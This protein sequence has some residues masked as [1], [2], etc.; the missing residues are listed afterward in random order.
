MVDIATFQNTSQSDYG[1]MDYDTPMQTSSLANGK[2][3]SLQHK[4]IIPSTRFEEMQQAMLL[5]LLEKELL[6][7]WQEWKN[8]LD[9]YQCS[10]T[11]RLSTASEDTLA[12]LRADAIKFRHLVEISNQSFEQTRHFLIKLLP[13]LRVDFLPAIAIDTEGEL[14]LEWYGRRGARASVTV[15]ANGVLYFVSLFHGASLK[16]RLLWSNI[17]PPIILTELDK[18]YRDKNI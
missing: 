10:F 12:S 8:E 4:R 6:P 3:W 15:G 13:Y 16:S 14:D 2:A 18:I 9:M 17:I 11:E 1:L 7:T 5:I